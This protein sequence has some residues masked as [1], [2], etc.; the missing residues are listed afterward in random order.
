MADAER[1]LKGQHNAI[2]LDNENAIILA[3]PEVFFLFLFCFFKNES[4]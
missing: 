2:R 4:T 1:S 3:P